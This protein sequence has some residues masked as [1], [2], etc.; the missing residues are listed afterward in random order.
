MAQR[1]FS[2][3]VRARIRA[4]IGLQPAA[5]L[6]EFSKIFP[7]NGGADADAQPDEPRAVEGGLRLTLAVDKT[8]YK[9]RDDRERLAAG[10]D[11]AALLGL[12]ASITLFT[13]TGFW[14][15]SGIAGL[16]YYF[17]DDCVARTERRILVAR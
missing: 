8:R 4:A 12:A 7:E 3:R 10:L 5:V 2:P 14:A 6:V 9:P 1:N 13:G 17:G 16:I 15:T 11:F